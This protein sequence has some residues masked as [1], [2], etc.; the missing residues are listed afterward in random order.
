MGD[1]GYPVQEYTINIGEPIYP[2]LSLSRKESIDKM[3]EEN[4]RVWRE[5]YER[6]YDMP[7]KYDTEEAVTV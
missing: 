3:M 5:I 6:D 1:D 2:D 7:L 4:A